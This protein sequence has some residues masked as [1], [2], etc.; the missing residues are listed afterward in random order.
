MRRIATLIRDNMAQPRQVESGTREVR[1]S[2]GKTV[3]AKNTDPKLAQIAGEF[4]QFEIER[5]RG[6]YL[7]YEPRR[8]EPIARLRS[9]S[10]HRSLRA[11]LLVKRSWALAN[12]R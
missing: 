9:H 7:I 4:S 8:P 12:L 2:S 6:G 11:V 10:E 5:S 3:R 1:R